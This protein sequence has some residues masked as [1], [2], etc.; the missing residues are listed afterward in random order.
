MP[1]RKKST[2]KPKTT[3]SKTNRRGKVKSV[4]KKK[5][6]KVDAKSKAKVEKKTE[7]FLKKKVTAKNVERK[8]K[9]MKKARSKRDA[10]SDGAGTSFR[11]SGT[12]QKST[13]RK[14][15]K[16]YSKTTKTLAK[17]MSTSGS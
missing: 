1:V 6:D 3:Y 4:S 14:G 5:Y 8:S 17:R 11:G 12:T 9:A 16:V 15:G 13:V 7:K 10:G 2:P